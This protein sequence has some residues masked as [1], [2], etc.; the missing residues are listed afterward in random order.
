[1]APYGGQTSS[2]CGGLVAFCHQIEALRAP[3]LVKL[4]LGALHNPP[5][6]SCGGLMAFTHLISAMLV[7]GIGC[8]CFIHLGTPTR[9]FPGSFV[10]IRLV[11]LRNCQ[12]T[13]LCIF[14]FLFVFCLFV[15]CLFVVCL[16]FVCCSFVKAGT[17]PGFYFI[18]N[19]AEGWMSI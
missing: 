14:C 17:I 11:W 1:M 3:W 16:L 19:G 2:S 4:K 15:C 7:Y 6:S 10:K 8:F 12:F 18:N 9:S 13:Q 5:S